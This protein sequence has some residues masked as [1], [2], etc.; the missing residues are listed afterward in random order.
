MSLLPPPLLTGRARAH[1]IDAL[2]HQAR[3]DML[4]KE[5][6]KGYRKLMGFNL[7]PWQRDSVWTLPQQQRFIESIFLGLGTGYYVAT[8]IE[9]EEKRR[10]EMRNTSLLLL[11]GQQRITAIQD[12]INNV[13]SVFDNIHYDDLSN[14]D[15]RNRFR[16]TAFPCIE[17]SA[18]SDE[19]LLKE[20]YHRLNFGGTAHG[21]SDLACLERE[22]L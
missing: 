16:H 11:D 14:A 2:L 4:T 1:T 20:L 9:Y 19:S 10:H 6:P 13:F 7:P 22:T 18:N 15:K 5:A 3:D 8:D 12:F 17:L 21:V